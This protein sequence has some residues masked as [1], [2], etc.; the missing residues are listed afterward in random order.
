MQTRLDDNL[1]QRLKR[2]ARGKGK[3]LNA[4]V[5]EILMREAPAEP[6]FPHFEGPLEIPEFLKSLCTSA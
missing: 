2:Q 4:H 5:E 6:E 3:S 1:I